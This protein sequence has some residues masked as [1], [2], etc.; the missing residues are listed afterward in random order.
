MDTRNSRNGLVPRLGLV[1]TSID[2][3]NPKAKDRAESA[4]RRLFE[5]LV[6]AKRIDP[7]SLVIGRVENPWQ[8]TDAARKLAA[9]GADLIAIANV[10]FPNGQV[11]LT[12]AT[13]PTLAKTPLVVMADPEPSIGEWATNAWCGV[14]MNNYVA[15]RLG[16]HIVTLPGP[17]DGPT[18]RTAFERVLSVARAIRLLRNDYL[19]RFGDAPS[20]FHSATDDQIAF[21]GVFGTRVDTVDLSAVM[22]VFRS[23]SARGY[24]GTQS[25]TDADVEATAREI[26]TQAEILVDHDMLTRGVRLY[27]ALRA[28]VRANGYTSAACRC[29]PE[30]NEPVIGISSCMAMGQLLAR[31]D[32]TAAGCEG[33]WPTAVAQT[34]GTLLTGKPAACLDWVNYTAGSEIVQLGHCGM[35]IC[36]HMAPCAARASKGGASPDS[37][38]NAIACHP[39]LRQFGKT[40]GPVHIG[41]FEYGPKTGLCILRTTDGRFKLLS[42]RGESSP[43]TAKGILYSATDVKVSDPVRLNRL[44]I[45]HGFPHH[46]AVALGDMSAEVAMLCGY[47]GIE[48]V[49]PDE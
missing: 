4:V 23:G 45:E 13:H 9:A 34:I 36:G 35:G 40:M 24:F 32:V 33:D 29:W 10:A 30:S 42:F 25:F 49:T 46:L 11:F 1:T 6:A 12:I 21:A 41:Q 15:K 7:A 31:G 48:H 28:I 26:S 27:H 19:C 5:E 2:G 3:F 22:E 18:F 39:V 17:T 14:I 44:I 16:R 38:T 20:G 43:Q 47:L 37:P 8:A